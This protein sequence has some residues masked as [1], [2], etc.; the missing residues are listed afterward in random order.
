[1]IPEQKLVH[2]SMKEKGWAYWSNDGM[3]KV[4]VEEV[5][6]VSRALNSEKAL[7]KGDNLDLESELGDVFYSLICLANCNQ[8]N[9]NDA[10][11]KSMQKYEVR[12]KDRYA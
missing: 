1:M 7:K 5:G 11:R 10:L 6:E 12:D 8:I 3:F 4:L 9:L 2:D